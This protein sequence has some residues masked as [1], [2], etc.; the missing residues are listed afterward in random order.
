MSI[1]KQQHVKVQLEKELR[2][3][4]ERLEK[5]GLEKVPLESL[6][7]EPSDTKIDEVKSDLDGFDSNEK[8]KQWEL[9]NEWVTSAYLRVLCRTPDEEELQTAVSF[10]TDSP[11][12]GDGLESLMWTL[13]NTKE[14]IL[15]H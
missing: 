3:A 2:Q 10:I 8:S 7:N 15:S 13:L 4:N 6:T 1:A 14:F 11:Q 12:P 5:I 9:F